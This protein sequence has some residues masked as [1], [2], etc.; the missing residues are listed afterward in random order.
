MRWHP[1]ESRAG[2]VDNR[3]FRLV[4]GA[5]NEFGSLSVPL[6]GRAGENVFEAGHKPGHSLGVASVH[7]TQFGFDFPLFAQGKTPVHDKQNGKHRQC[8][9]GRPLEQEPNQNQDEADI[10]RM[11][12]AGVRPRGRERSRPLCLV[13]DTP[14]GREQDEPAADEAETDVA[15][16]SKFSSGAKSYEWWSSTKYEQFEQRQ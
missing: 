7:V 15:A 10:L 5:D 9:N 6:N 1:V 11:A 3:S 16:Y 13:K 12:N 2:A 4:Y 14:S 8:E